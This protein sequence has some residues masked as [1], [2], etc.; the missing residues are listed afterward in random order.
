[1]PSV[2]GRACLNSVHV[3]LN[4]ELRY[5]E[6]RGVAASSSRPMPGYCSNRFFSTLPAGDS[7]I[8]NPQ[9][10]LCRYVALLRSQPPPAGTVMSGITF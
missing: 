5:L 9:L 1:M 8:Y 6:L 7:C 4:R 2:Y 10:S 3:S